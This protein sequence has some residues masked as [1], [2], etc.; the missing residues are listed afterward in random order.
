MEN[1][2]TVVVVSWVMQRRVMPFFFAV[3]DSVGSVCAYQYV[4]LRVAYP[5]SSCISI[6]SAF[7][8][9]NW[10]CIEEASVDGKTKPKQSHKSHTDYACRVAEIWQRLSIEYF[11]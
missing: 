10:E 4:R 3:C 9:G 6:T 2:I 8:T 5:R 1:I 11:L 7:Y